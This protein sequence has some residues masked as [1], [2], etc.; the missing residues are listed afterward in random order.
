MVE[1][2]F[3][4]ALNRFSR[5]RLPPPLLLSYWC[6]YSC[7]M[8]LIFSLHLRYEVYEIKNKRRY[9]CEATFVTI[10]R[11]CW[12][13]A[14]NRLRP[15]ACESFLRS[16]LVLQELEMIYDNC[17]VTD[18]YY[19]RWMLIVGWSDR[20]VARDYCPRIVREL[21]SIQHG[22]S[23]VWPYTVMW[24]GPFSGVRKLRDNFKPQFAF[25]QWN[26]G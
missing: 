2:S 10:F 15:G 3:P 23:S 20:P 26:R 4:I 8:I 5:T 24:S 22:T 6:L 14:R 25:Q 9:L 21:K 16:P 18:R 19:C 11:A 13:R 7:C 12:T 1:R 17:N